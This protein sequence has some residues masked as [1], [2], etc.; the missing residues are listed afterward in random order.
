MPGSFT[1]WSADGDL[2]RFPIRRGALLR[3]RVISMVSYG[4]IAMSC[5]SF[6]KQA[7]T[8]T[9]SSQASRRPRWKRRSL[10]SWIGNP[11]DRNG[12]RFVPVRPDEAC[13]GSARWRDGVPHTLEAAS[14]GMAISVYDPRESLPK[15]SSEHEPRGE[16][17]IEGTLSADRHGEWASCILEPC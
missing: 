7:H 14:L 8:T 16:V 13:C 9:S 10:T 6:G 17:Y 1:L 4:V 15:G 3:P 12:G 5:R 11:S 2:V